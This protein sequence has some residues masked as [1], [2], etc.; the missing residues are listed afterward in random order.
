MNTILLIAEE[1]S[2]VAYFPEVL[3]P[4]YSVRCVSTEDEGLRSM[5]ENGKGVVAV[6]IE[7]ALARRS[8]FTF[9]AQYKRTSS[10]SAVPMIAISAALPSE[11][12]MDC[13][14]HG[15][16]DL[17]TAYAPRELIC[18]RINN[19]IRASDSLSLAELEKMLK[20]LPACIFLKDTECRYVF[21]T[22]YWHHLNTGGDPDW[23]I[24]GKTDLDIRKDKENARKA[25]EAD[26]R[27]LETGQGTEYI[28]EENQDGI[29]DYLQLIKRPVFDESGKVSGIIALINNVT[30]YQLLKLELEKRAKTDALTG[31]L[32]KSAAQDLIRMMLANY[33]T[34]EDRCALLM[35]DIDLFKRVNDTFGHAEGDRV[36]AEVGRIINN[37]CR[38]LDVAG[39]IGGDEFVIFMRNIEAPDNA[40]QLASRLSSQVQRAFRGEK[41]EGRVT[42]SIGVAVYPDHG[43]RFDDLFQAADAALYHVKNHGRAAVALYTPGEVPGGQGEL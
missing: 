4:Y 17:I 32:N 9:E 3:S 36:L 35:I 43:R 30:D 37:N 6:L 5:D 22:Q 10:F 14:E 23:T 8:H 7:L 26:R 12:D 25:M 2:I 21:S 11:Q 16:Y 34:L 41:L 15:F 33:H 38:A 31:L 28:I 27:I 24:R 18:K 19:A 13:I 20:V 39:R 40:V 42:L 29:R 1:P